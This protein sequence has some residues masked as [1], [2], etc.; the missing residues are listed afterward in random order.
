MEK[1]AGILEGNS[2]WAEKTNKDHP[3]LFDKLANQQ[4]P[5]FLWIGCSDSRVPATQICKQ[6]PGDMFV[7]RNV[8]NQVIP[9]DLSCLTALQF[10]VEVLKVTD[11]IVCGH[12]GCGGVNAAMSDESFGLIDNWL[13]HIKKLFQSK[14]AE[15][16]QILNPEL[17]ANKLT[18]L[19]VQKQLANLAASEA[20]QKAWSQ[21][22]ELKLHGLVYQLTNGKLLNL[23]LTTGNK[24]EAEK[25][26]S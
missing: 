8:A 11:I 16:D 15:L 17:R 22:Q 24:A 12:Y 9:N 23:N 25:L 10:A 26:L 3:D 6:L 21:G 7:H 20:V 18:E 13:I 2:Q 1:L 14:K 5:Q 4:N 19:N